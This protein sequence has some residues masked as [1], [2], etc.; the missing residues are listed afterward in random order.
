MKKL[1]H[2][3]TPSVNNPSDVSETKPTGGAESV[4]TFHIDAQRFLD[5]IAPGGRFAFQT[6]TDKKENIKNGDDPLA[7]QLFGSVAQHH[8]KLKSLNDDGA[9]VYVAPNEIKGNRRNNSAVSRV[10]ACWLDLDGSPLE[11]VLQGPLMPHIVTQTSPGRW[12]CFWCVSDLNADFDSWKGIQLALAKRFKGDESMKNLAGVMRVPGY[13]HKKKEPHLVTIEQFNDLPDYTA[14]E[15]LKAFINSDES[16]DDDV[17]LSTEAKLEL[18]KLTA[19]LAVMEESQTTKWG[20]GR[21][22][23]LNNMVHHMVVDFVNCG[24]I[25]LSEVV[26]A[27]TDAAI[28]CDCPGYKATI[29]SATVSALAKA[30]DATPFSEQWLALRLADRYKDLRYVG[31]WK[32]WMHWDGK[33]WNEDEKRKV[34]YYAQKICRDAAKSPRV[35]NKVER[36]RLQ[37]ASCRAAV[38]NLAQDLPELIATV[39]QW[40]ADPWL[41]NTP[42]G[43][44]DLTTS[45]LTPHDPQA[46]MTKMTAVAPNFDMET[47]I[48]NAYL[49]KV[50]PDTE[51]RDYLQRRYGYAL[52]GATREETLDFD[53]GEGANGKGTMYSTVAGAVGDYHAIAPMS[54]FLASRNESHP[55]DVAH[56]A[57]AR[58]ATATEIE[59]GRSWNETKIKSLTGGD[60][61][62][63]RRMREDFWDFSPKFK[64]H[65]SG[66]NQPNL[67]SVDEAIRRRLIMVPWNVVVPKEERDLQLKEKLKHEWPGILAWMIKGCLVWQ[68]QG[69]DP[70][71]AV[72]EATNE[73]LEEQDPMPEFIA[74]YFVKGEKEKAEA[75][76]VYPAWREFKE[77]RGEHPGRQNQFVEKM[78][79]A[80]FSQDKNEKVRFYKGLRQIKFAGQGQQQQQQAMTPE[81]QERLKMPTEF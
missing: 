57:G 77:G 4:I 35:K 42:S 27:F 31:K 41:L 51:I 62:T 12:H 50:Q 68:E 6:F 59:E 65:I 19:E 17:N 24:A 10:R 71:K 67:K 43:I 1:K 76:A 53:Y 30:D 54:V 8:A 14:A 58:L 61:I 25:P 60:K 75:N 3:G 78:R 36:Q 2:A 39:E 13:Y 7:R 32:K 23:N 64:L 9:G 46:F 73:Y 21:N 74:E 18:E 52:T 56:L 11:P 45:E 37:S 81:Q 69:L 63:A 44:V 33:R 5:R 16:D 22:A 34:F 26:Q 38:V 48:F 49:E 80:G 15:M 47:P 20:V 79:R 40:D 72:I 70:P 66:N 28:A 29:E 55:T